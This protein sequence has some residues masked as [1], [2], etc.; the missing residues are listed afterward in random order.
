MSVPVSFLKILIFTEVL[1]LFEPHLVNTG[2][3]AYLFRRIIVI[4]VPA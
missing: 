3:F 4:P 2:N 1:F